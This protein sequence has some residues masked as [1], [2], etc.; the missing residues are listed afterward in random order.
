MKKVYVARFLVQVDTGNNAP[1]SIWRVHDDIM[2]YITKINEEQYYFVNSHTIK[3]EELIKQ[4]PEKKR[5][6]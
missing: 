6:R 3:V 2:Q 1:I 4:E 5:R